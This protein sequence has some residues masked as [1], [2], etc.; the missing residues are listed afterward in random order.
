[1]SLTIATRTQ[2][3]LAALARDA[4]IVQD[5]SRMPSQDIRVGYASMLFDAAVHGSAGVIELGSA[6]PAGVAVVGGV[7]HVQTALTSGATAA[8][9]IVGANDVYSAG[10]GFQTTGLKA[11]VPSRTAPLLVATGAKVKLTLSGTAAAAGKLL[12]VLEL[13][14]VL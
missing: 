2:T 4:E 7:V 9:H 5:Q 14:K 3:Q 8:L 13:V 1:M 10:S 12:V 6:L 11:V